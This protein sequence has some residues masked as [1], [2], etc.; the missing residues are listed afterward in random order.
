MKKIIILLGFIASILVIQ[1]STNASQVVVENAISWAISIANDDSHGYSRSNR[2]GPDY[3]CSSFVISAFKS[4]GIDTGTAVNTR[5]MRSQ[6]TQHGFQW[7]PW[8]QIGGESNLQRGDVLLNEGYTGQGHTEIYLGNGQN[9][10]AHSNRGYP[11]TGDQTGTEVSVSGFY[12][13]PWDGVLRYKDLGNNPEGIT[14]YGFDSPTEGEVIARDVWQFSGWVR[15][16][17]SIDS[18]TCSINGGQR[19]ITTGLY[20]REDVPGATAFRADISCNDL[21]DGSNN[22]AICVNYTDGTGVVVAS[23]NIIKTNSRVLSHGFDS[24]R[25]ND[26][27]SGLT[28][29]FQG[30]INASKEIDTITC[31]IND[32]K[33]Y[34]PTLLYT[35]EDVP[36]ATAFRVEIPTGWLDVGRNTVS[37]CVNYK[38]G[39]AETVERREVNRT[40][41][42]ELTAFDEPMDNQYMEENTFRVLGW[43]QPDYE[44]EAV[45]CAINNYSVWYDL[46]TYERE[47]VKGAIGFQETFSSNL[48]GYGENPIVLRIKYTNGIISY[49]ATK[50]VKKTFLDAIDYPIEDE[51]IITNGEGNFEKNTYRIQGWTRNDTKS[52]DNFVFNINGTE[53]IREAYTRPD[54]S[55]KEKGFLWDIPLELFIDGENR[56]DLTVQYTDGTSRDIH[57]WEFEGD[58]FVEDIILDKTNLSLN[59]GDVQQLNV[60]V[61]PSNAGNKKVRWESKDKNIVTVDENGEVSAVG[62][63]TTLIK[64]TTEDGDITASCIVN[65]GTNIKDVE[66]TLSKNEFDYNGNNIEPDIVVENDGYILQKNRD[67][68]VEYNNN[69][70]AGK[71]QICVKGMGNYY[72]TVE[73]SF[74]I[75]KA[76]QTLT[77]VIPSDEIFVGEIFQIYVTGIGKITYSSEDDTI[78]MINSDGKIV[79]LKEGTADIVI[80]AEGDSNHNVANKTITVSVKEKESECVHEWDKGIVQKDATCTE[81]GEILYTCKKCGITKI[82]TINLLGHTIVEDSAIAATCETEGKTE[83]KHC[84]VCGEVL[85]KQEVIPAKGH[86]EVIDEAVVATCEAEGKTEGKHCSVCGEVLKKQEVIP[87]KGHTEV[88]DEEVVAT[89]ETEG[90]TEG[91]HC[92]ACGETLK[93][94]EVIPAKGHTVVTDKAVAATCEIEGKTEGKHCSVCDEVL[95]K[96]EVIPAKGHTVVTDKAVAATCGTAGKTEGSHCSVCGKELKKQEVIPAKGHFFDD[97]VIEKPATQYEEGLKVYTCSNCGLTRTEVIAK[98]PVTEQEKPSNPGAGD[99]EKT[100]PEKPKAEQPKREEAKSTE[101]KVPV[102]SVLVEEKTGGVYKVLRVS[103]GTGEVQYMKPTGTSSTA[104]VPDT[105]TI[106][107]ISYRVTEICDNAFK[108]NKNLRKVVIGRYVKR[109]GKNAFANCKRLQSV[110]MGSAVTVIDDKAF[111]K[112]TSLK[113]I[114]IPG[115]IVKIGKKAFFGAKKLKTITIKTKKLTM[116][117]VGS[118]AFKGIYAKAKIKVPKAKK[119]LYRNVLRKRGVSGRAVIK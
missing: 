83:G 38:D 63:G 19:Y 80:T 39:T 65:V 118:K 103:G 23:R 89:C 90:R 20:T 112:C 21:N 88:I 3:D 81:S 52:V 117:T 106:N 25:S 59:P 30:W 17:K 45:Q 4:A 95:K 10:G 35:R 85:K 100:E 71:G 99:A 78:V 92:S 108:G 66:I 97:G 16:T 87:A 15:T 54:L 105:V 58:F 56:I 74:V 31:S 73:K 57:T 28:W 11:Q 12:I 113:K 94:Q 7:I 22:V 60:E 91:K 5:N 77:V 27:I 53:Y 111:F 116:K 109:I 26:N 102:G 50:K 2:W 51:K 110:T 36:G 68:I 33:Y 75:N 37:V 107:G 79:A 70:Y 41:P 48:L 61:C 49:L 47:D 32:G 29:L 40:R 18:I 114:T 86:T 13:H 43:V 42:M 76:N 72:G 6:F 104:V 119:K 55:D 64:V 1:T 34:I 93:K 14:A 101:N 62:C 69:I 46:S 44:V 115:Q 98:L 84:S 8:S 82:V 67:Y 9:V 24:P 96:Q